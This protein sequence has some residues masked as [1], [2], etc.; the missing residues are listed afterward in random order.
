MRH[1]LGPTPVP[2]DPPEVDPECAL[3]NCPLDA[4]TPR[5][6]DGLGAE[7]DRGRPFDHDPERLLTE[8]VTSNLLG[9]RDC[10]RSRW[11]RQQ[12]ELSERA[13]VGNP[14]M[15]SFKG[16]RDSEWQVIGSRRGPKK[17]EGPDRSGF[18]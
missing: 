1:A 8:M 4:G 2:L 15:A 14:T 7:V 12:S 13:E 10:Y 16:R 5:S 18:D 3:E 6:P 17:A 9:T 11:M